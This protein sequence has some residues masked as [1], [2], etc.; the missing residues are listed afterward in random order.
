[1]N[2][3]KEALLTK[4]LSISFLNRILSVTEYLFLWG[5]INFDISFSQS[6]LIEEYH[7]YGVK[8]YLQIITIG[9]NSVVVVFS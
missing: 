8:K 2:Y 9:N 6:S 5:G 1:M 4:C 7:V 3:Y